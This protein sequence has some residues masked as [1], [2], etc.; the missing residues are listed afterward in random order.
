MFKIISR[1]DTEKLLENAGAFSSI[2]CLEMGLSMYPKYYRIFCACQY[3]FTGKQEDFMSQLEA[4]SL[5]ATLPDAQVTVIL[6]MTQGLPVPMIQGI[7]SWAK[8]RLGA[9]AVKRF[10]P[11][12]L[13][14]EDFPARLTIVYHDIRPRRSY[15]SLS[16][17]PSEHLREVEHCIA[18]GLDKE[19]MRNR[20]IDVLSPLTN[21]DVFDVM[22]EHHFLWSGIARS[23]TSADEVLTQLRPEMEQTGSEYAVSGLILFLEVDKAFTCE[24][25]IH[26]LV[27]ALIGIAGG[28]DI[29]TAISTRIRESH[30][31]S[32][33][34]RAA[35]IGNP[36]Y[37]KGEVYYDLGK[38]EILLH[39][40][41]NKKSG[42]MIVATIED[43]QFTLARY[44]WGK[45]DYSPSGRTDDHHYF[46]RD[47][48]RRL[49]EALHRKNPDALL[50]S[51]RKRFA[52]SYSE[53]SDTAFLEFCRKQGIRCKSDYHY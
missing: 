45:Y 21:S 12:Y 16:R 41:D 47:N 6:E 5:P 37:I 19:I 22:Y 53:D 20:E 46:D 33:T 39:E 50:R 35:L 49:Y 1:T 40:S 28:K 27:Q 43:E 30:I 11:V 44:D 2:S 38:Y 24:G 32:I 36:K 23:N 31:K 10:V 8:N 29:E 51:I 52:S 7:H 34:C 3:T 26:N 9:A 14:T 13:Y 15:L 42:H 18:K 17:H 4:S 25:E 48:T